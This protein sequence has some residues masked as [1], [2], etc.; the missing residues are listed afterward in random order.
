MSCFSSNTVTWKTS[1]HTLVGTLPGV[2][3]SE[4]YISNKAASDGDGAGSVMI[5][6]DP[7]R[8]S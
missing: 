1:K 5:L 7:L 3:D 6:G 2:S 4:V 8:L